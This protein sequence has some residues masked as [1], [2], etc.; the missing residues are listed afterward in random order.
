MNYFQLEK[1]NFC[2][3]DDERSDNEHIRSRRLCKKHKILLE[4][5]EYDP[6]DLR[7]YK[8]AISFIKKRG[9]D[10]TNTDISR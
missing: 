8:V 2:L 5:E 10:E 4:K 1:C 7:A 3:V 9:L 6:P